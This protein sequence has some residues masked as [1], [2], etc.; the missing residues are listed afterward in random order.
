VSR[1]LT[2]GEPAPFPSRT[3]PDE[4][5]V[6]DPEVG[7]VPLWQL[8]AWRRVKANQE[9]FRNDAVADDVAIHPPI[10]MEGNLPVERQDAPQ[11]GAPDMAA[12][13]EQ[14]AAAVEALV[15]RIQALEID[16]SEQARRDPSGLFPALI[17]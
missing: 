16:R 10:K 8:Q 1:I 15:V 3:Y 14:L 12:I 5:M 13:I 7:L 4:V 2:N 11:D 6:H 17:N 9:H